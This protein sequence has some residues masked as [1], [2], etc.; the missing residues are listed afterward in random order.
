MRRISPT[1]VIGKSKKPRGFPKGMN[2]LPVVYIN[3]R[4]VLMTSD[5]F[6]EWLEI[7]DR[8]LVHIK[9]NILLLVDNCSAHPYSI[10]VVNIKLHF[11]PPNT[12]SLMQPMDIGVIHN[13]KAFYRSRLNIRIITA[14]DADE[15]TIA[16]AVSRSVTVLDALYIRVLGSQLNK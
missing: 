3:S 5:L 11:L 14:L 4:N 1:S 2:N 13:L 12:T 15:D 16:L 8:Q 10:G 6:R 9:R 7:W